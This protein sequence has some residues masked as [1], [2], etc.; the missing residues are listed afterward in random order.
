MNEMKIMD[1]RLKANL[2]RP[3]SERLEDLVFSVFFAMVPLLL[4]FAFLFLARVCLGAPNVDVFAEIEHT[5]AVIEDIQSN[6]PENA[7][8]SALDQL[9]IAV[10]MQNDAHRSFERGQLIIA[11][12]LTLQAREI[13]IRVK[14][15][16][17]AL[18]IG[19]ASKPPEAVA[20]MLE[21]NDELIEELTPIID[22]R[23]SEPT[24]EGFSQT[25]SMQ[26]DARAFFDAQSYG[27]SSRLARLVNDRLN[28]MR[29]EVIRNERR[30]APERAESEI[31]K[32]GDIIARANERISEENREARK[33]LESAETMLDEARKLYS[34]GKTSQAMRLIDEVSSLTQ[35]AIRLSERKGFDGDYIADRI[36]LTDEIISSAQEEVVPTGNREAIAILEKAVEVQSQA[37]TAL[38][39]REY[40]LAEE[41]TLEARKNAELAKRT[42]QETG[43]LS[44]LEVERAIQNTENLYLRLKPMI[45]ESRSSEA[46]NLMHQ[47]ESL[48]SQAIALKEQGKY[49]EAITTTR[50]AMDNLQRSARLI[51]NK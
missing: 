10:D 30:L 4:I 40:R 48:Q 43:K 46:K 33:I 22:E 45:E 16:L 7:P 51:E 21:K 5:D 1:E 14:R 31:E 39:S 50:A 9:S 8:Q 35:K 37:K 28:A 3:F 23:A 41:F 11:L 29:D 26:F 42:A 49:K 38:E 36:A 6:I 25:V 27:Q 44:D 15:I 32:A 47:A 34:E 13:A 17:D 2:E 24:R 18:I 20:R 19:N 12:N